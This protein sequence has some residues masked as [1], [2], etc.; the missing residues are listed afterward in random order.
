MEGKLSRFLKLITILVIFPISVFA[1]DI[2]NDCRSLIGSEAVSRSEF[3]FIDAQNAIEICAAALHTYPEDLDVRYHLAR[4]HDAARNHRI[5]LQLYQMGA[6]SGHAPSMFAVGWFHYAGLET[7]EDRQVALRWFQ[8]AASAG[9]G[10]AFTQ[11][12]YLAANDQ[13]SALRW[14]RR[15]AELG[16]GAAMFRLGLAYHDGIGV[17]RNRKTAVA[18]F[19]KGAL[20]GN[21]E[22]MRQL[23]R[24]YLL[25]RGVRM[26][27]S[28]GL[29]WLRRA[30]D[31]SDT[32]AMFT[33]AEFWENGSSSIPPNRKK[34]AYWQLQLLKF[35]DFPEGSIRNIR[36]EVSRPTLLEIQRILQEAGVYDGA[37]DG[38]FGPQT[39]AALEA[40]AN[41]E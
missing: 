26:N 3:N 28:E 19:E 8:D 41:L 36:S 31:R 10:E 29:D 35:G 4:A 23:G 22:A 1:E 13:T 9:S 6:D 18:W 14:F 40:Y 25:G 20:A 30:A 24:A 17:T 39:R 32:S 7:R 34:A 16:D 38:A 11:L 5:A 33:L 27:P 15:A 2:R 12:G 37:L 21:P